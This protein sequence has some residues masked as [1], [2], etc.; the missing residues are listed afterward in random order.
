MPDSFPPAVAALIQRNPPIVAAVAT[1][2]ADGSPQV[3]Y[4]WYEFDG[5]RFRFSTTDDRV[6][7]RNLQRDPRAVISL[8]D[9]DNPYRFVSI[10]CRATL[11]KEGA[12]D[13]ILRLAIKYQGE[14]VGRARGA[15][16]QTPNRVVVTLDPT[17][18]Y[19]YG[20]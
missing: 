10:P 14:E 16:M 8:L 20:F 17:D 6:K 11:S 18:F 12:T 13:L 15:G 1:I 7:Y 2:N 19:S 3:T 9:P 4:V 5:Q